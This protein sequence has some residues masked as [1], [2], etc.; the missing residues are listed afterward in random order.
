MFPG[1][2]GMSDVTQISLVEIARQMAESPPS[3]DPITAAAMDHFELCRSLSDAFP[4]QFAAHAARLTDLRS[5]LEEL[6]LRRGG[7]GDEAER[8]IP[9]VPPEALAESDFEQFVRRPCPVIFEGAARDVTA[10]RQWTPEYFGEH[11]GDYPC[12][13]ATED[14]WDIPGTLSDAI[15]DIL[16]PKEE[17]LYAQNIANIFNDHPDL[18]GELELERFLPIS[19]GAGTWGRT[20]FIGG[21]KTGTNFHC[22]NNLN[23]F[24][25]VHGRKEWFFVHP[26]H[27][28][29]M[30]GLLHKTGGYGDSPVDHRR[31]AIEQSD[32]FPLYAQVPVYSA[33]LEPGD[34]LI[35][36]PWWW[37]AVNN[38]TDAT[39]ACAVRWTPYEIEDSNPV[40]SLAQSLM[41]HTKDVRR[42]LRDP[43]ARIT[44][45]L[46]REGFEPIRKEK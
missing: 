30:Y 31:P 44:D 2:K 42:A 46:Y 3:A 33:R 45:E 23:I 6:L 22:A 37:H 29:W 43:K 11:Y 17:N 12:L 20:C 9:R 14:K 36:P 1:P 8:D 7:A 19:A 21:S 15:D 28:F 27:T 41:P 38:L 4:M 32:A 39:I 13:L 34:V 10:V 5:R 16:H 24:F 35:N 18:E 26:K 40:F 25:N